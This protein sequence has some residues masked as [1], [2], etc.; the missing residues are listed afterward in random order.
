MN[1]DS[2]RSSALDRWRWLPNALTLLRILLVGPFALALYREQYLLALCLFLVAAVTD[3]LDGLLARVFNW[4]SRFGAIADPL[5]DKLLL[6]TA[7]L[8]LALTDVIPW[9][10]FALVLLRDLIIVMGGVLFH[11]IIS[12]VDVAPTRAG[13]LNTLIQILGA[14]VIM[15]SQSGQMFPPAALDAVIV[16]VAVAAVISGGN[17]VWIWG[18]KAW[19][20]R[21]S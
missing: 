16:L 13:K 19:R 7:W 12:R 17:Y 20:S 21:A 11:R 2:R 15:L 18:Q 4:R 5:A 6:V 10:L 1:E 14:L 8:M 3:G 9:W